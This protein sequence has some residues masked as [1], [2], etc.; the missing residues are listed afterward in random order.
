[1][2][3][4]LGVLGGTFDPPHRMHLRVA[5]AAREA[6]DLPRVLFVPAGDPWRKA[7][8]S[9]TAA[10]HRLT[11]TRRAIAADPAFACSDMEIR[12]PGPSQALAT[13]EA[14]RAQGWTA[15]WFILGSDALLDLPHWHQPARLIATARLAVVVRPGAE[16]GRTDLEA[17]VPG[18]AGRVDWLRLSPDPLS[19]S[20]VRA[21]LAAGRPAGADLPPAVAGYIRRHGL[22]GVPAEGGVSP[23]RR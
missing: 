5:A 11:M 19:A 23:A 15:L 14:L 18:L 10:A 8:R 3:G 16:L 9:V 6:L 2:A 20:D 12:R 4:R 21:R 22:Y 7:D 1:M 13:L 17:L